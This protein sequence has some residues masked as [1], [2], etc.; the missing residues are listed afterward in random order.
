MSGTLI[1][2]SDGLTTPPMLRHVVAGMKE[3]ARAKVVIVT[4]ASKNKERN[5]YSLRAHA[6]YSELGCESV[7]FVDIEAQPTFDFSSHHLIHVC[8][9]NTFKLLH[10]ARQSNFKRS[11]EELLSRHGVYVGVSAGTII[12]TPS[13]QFVDDLCLDPNSIE[14]T[15]F[16][17]FNLIPQNIFVHYTPR[18][19]KILSSYEKD[20]AC[21]FIRITNEQAVLI[22]NNTVEII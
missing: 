8:G 22:K 18:W 16:Q 1:L 14:M 6:Q 17:S 9:G 20:I 10:I 11:V 21:S 2:T 13:I 12:L 3:L 5:P 4:T 7:Q 19:E 15:D